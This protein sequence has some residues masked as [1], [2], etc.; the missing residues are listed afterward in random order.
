MSGSLI[1][2]AQQAWEQHWLDTIEEHFCAARGRVDAVYECQFGSARAV[3]QRHW[4]HK[5]DIPRDLL[6]LPRGLW[7]ASSKVFGLKSPK[8]APPPSQKELAISRVLEA[9]L[10]QLSQ[11]QQKLI[12]HLQSHPDLQDGQWQE[13][14]A[15]LGGYSPDAARFYLEKAVNQLT[16]T[17]EGSR[18]FLLFVSLG[19]LGR[20]LCEKV[21]FG[22]AVSLGSAAASGIYLS[23]QSFVGSLWASW[24]GVPGW[25]TVSGAVTGVGVVLVATP[26]IA[27]LTE[28]GINRLRA[29]KFLHRL[30]DQVEQQLQHPGKDIGSL[31]GQMG[32]YLQ[33]LPD[34]IQILKHL[35]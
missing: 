14:Q 5:S 19:L 4:R 12:L 13:L 29:R 1:P 6:N 21:A 2:T 24:F 32:S 18:D 11:L 3:W 8:A 27:P 20:G 22:G 35:R 30:V 7:R 10:L 16:L 23:Q 15:V 25:V 34:L 9:E 17:H 31:A 26:L 33:L 28:Y